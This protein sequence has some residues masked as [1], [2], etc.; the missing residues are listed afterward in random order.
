VTV[1]VVAALPEE[2]D[3][4][5]SLLLGV[6]VD[7]VTVAM[8]GAGRRRAETEMRALL[9]RHRPDAWIGA[10]LAGAATP[11][12][13]PGTLLVAR[14]AGD[15]EWSSRV[16]ARGGALPASVVTVDRVAWTGR[17]KADFA[18]RGASG[19]VV[20]LDMETAGWLAAAGGSAGSP[21]G[22]VIRVVSDAADEEIPDF[23]AAASSADGLDRRR[24]A[25]HALTHPSAVGKLL[26]MRRRARFCAERLAGFL[27]VLAR[28]GFDLS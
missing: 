12:I 10:G 7:S 13:P 24:I 27:E 5:R 3:P 22:L 15:P 1:L 21:P 6:G 18:S 25:L 23:V 8:T 16:L 28:R 11:G 26:A 17:E 2:F 9:A 4:I 19:D 20:A 14:N